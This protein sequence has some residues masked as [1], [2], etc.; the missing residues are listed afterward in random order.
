V[1]RHLSHPVTSKLPDFI[2]P[3][4]ATLVDKAPV[5]NDW[6][7]E[8]KFDGY[9]IGARLESG[10]VRM[11]TRKG[12][13]WAARFRPIAEAV[14]SLKVTNTYLDGEVAVLDDK[15]ISVFAALQDALSAG[16]AD[17]ISYHLFDLL[18][19]NGEDLRAL[20]LIERKARLEK[21]LGKRPPRPLAYCSHVL[22]QAPAFHRQACK[23][24]L[25]G[26]VS[27][28]A[29]SSY[30]SGRDTAWQKVKCRLRQEFVVGGW[31]QSDANGRT[32]SSL[33]VGYYDKGRLVFAGKLGTGFTEKIQRDLLARLAKLGPRPAP[34]F[35]SIPREYLKRAVWVRPELV[36]E[37]EFTTWTAD[38]LLRQAA[39]KGL[40]EDKPVR[41]VRHER[42][43]PG[44]RAAAKPRA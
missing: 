39:Y 25:E 32:L 20:P 43:I 41:E 35:E 36:V 23:M 40:R 17:R 26:I 12:L 27:K 5:G 29:R 44:N 14:A 38:H 7:S 8:I 19:L 9:R 15:G 34:P 13:D 31:R 33:L 11:L 10:R 21:L 42:A 24:G 28:L 18:W 2:A 6:V 4:L 22:G 30:Y 16:R 3:E 1:P 37:G